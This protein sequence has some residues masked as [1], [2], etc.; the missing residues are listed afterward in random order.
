M[1][2]KFIRVSMS[3][4]LYLSDM[5]LSFTSLQTSLGEMDHQV[6]PQNYKRNQEY[7]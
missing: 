5:Y 1:H 4:S 2:T 7:V 6:E 3:T